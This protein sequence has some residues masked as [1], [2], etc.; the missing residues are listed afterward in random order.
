[1][2]SW[3]FEIEVDNSRG[4]DDYWLLAEYL[5]KEIEQLKIESAVNELDELGF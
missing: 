3:E 5:R 1:M 2:K 4:L